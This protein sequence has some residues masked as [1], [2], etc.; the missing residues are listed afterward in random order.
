MGFMSGVVTGVALAA[1]A[2]AWYMSRSGERFRDQYRVEQR[3]G[4]IGDQLEART[5]EIQ[6][7]VNSQLAEMRAKGQEAVDAAASSGNGRQAGDALDAASATAAEAAAEAE[8]M[9]ERV[10]KAAKDVA[11]NAGS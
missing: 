1:G 2:A 5:R 10:K 6:S 9:T 7:T 3:L 11:E 4:E 8:A